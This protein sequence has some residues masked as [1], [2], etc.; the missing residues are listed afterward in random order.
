MS[1]ETHIRATKRH[2]PYE[3]TCH[4]PHP[5]PSQVGCSYSLYLPAEMEQAKLI[6][7]IGYILEWF[8]CLLDSTRPEVDSS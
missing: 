8:T 5:N 3:I 1:S 2:L 7:G 6:F 4:P